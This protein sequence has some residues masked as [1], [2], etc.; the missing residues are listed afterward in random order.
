MTINVDLFRKTLDHIETL[1]AFKEQG[2]D[3]DEVW[4]QR[5]WYQPV[6]NDEGNICGTKACFA[7]WACVLAGDDLIE[8]TVTEQF[9]PCGN[10]DCGCVGASYSYQEAFAVDQDGNRYDIEV[11]ARELLGVTPQRANWLFDYANDLD[12][13]RTRV[14]AAIKA[15]R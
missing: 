4:D 2:L 1:A 10:P 15:A 9:K 11:R 13:V 14:R 8:E 3:L 5:T 12:T 7:G 6:R